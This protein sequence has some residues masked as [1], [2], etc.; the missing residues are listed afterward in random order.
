[1]ASLVQEAPLPLL[2]QGEEQGAAAAVQ[3]VRLEPLHVLGQLQGGL[4]G[5]LQGQVRKQWEL[6]VA[7]PRHQ[8]Q[9]QREGLLQAH[10]RSC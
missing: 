6:G 1:M 5:Q 9:R 10:L 8:T 7:P 4:Q 3:V 2:G